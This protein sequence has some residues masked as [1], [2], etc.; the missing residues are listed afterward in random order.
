MPGLLAAVLI[1]ATGLVTAA[2][3]ATRHPYALAAVR[4]RESVIVTAAAFGALSLAT[5]GALTPLLE[6]DAADRPQ[7]GR[8]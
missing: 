4:S 8:Y 3:L 7:K 6:E 2:F 5:F 1:V